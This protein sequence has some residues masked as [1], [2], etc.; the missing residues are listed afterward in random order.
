MIDQVRRGS[1]ATWHGAGGALSGVFLGPRRG[2]VLA[3]MATLWWG[4]GAPLAQA[5]EAQVPGVPGIT[6]VGDGSATAQPDTTTIR[7]GVDVT[8]QTPAEALSRTRGGAEQVVQR[9]RERGVPEG[10]VQTSGL[11]VFP[12]QAPSRDGPPDPTAISGY[13]GNATIT[14]QARDVSQVGALLDAAIQAGATSV[15]GLSFGIRD[16]S[17]LRRRAMT[18]A[19]AAARPQAEA[20]AAAAGLTITGVRAIVEIPFGVPAARGAGGLGGGAGEGIAT[21]EL[22]VAVRVQVTFDVAR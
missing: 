17:T 15:Q 10:D 1:R 8:A 2:V 22:S 5:Q 20:A 21:G 11:N 3:M 6:V 12:I 9:L 4:L 18:A 14:A 16:D 7:L 13:R 19:I